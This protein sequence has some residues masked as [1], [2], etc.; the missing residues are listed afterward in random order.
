MKKNTS[1]TVKDVWEM[2]PGSTEYPSL[3]LSPLEP[4]YTVNTGGIPEVLKS[5][6]RWVNWEYGKERENDKREKIPINPRT[7]KRAE[8]NNP[9]TWGTF[10]EA[11]KRYDPCYCGLGFMLGDGWVGVDLDH[12]VNQAKE[13]EPWADEI[14][15]KIDSYSELSPSE[16]GVHII[17]RGELPHGG[18]RK[19]NIEMYDSVRFFTVTGQHLPKSPKTVEQRTETLQ[20]IHAQYI[21]NGKSDKNHHDESGSSPPP[22]TDDEIIEKARGAE[23]A[24]KFN[25]LWA[26]DKSEYD[27]DDSRADLAL[28]A[29]LAFWTKDADT[30]DRLFR[31]SGLLRPKWDERRGS[32]TYGKD[33]IQYALKTSNGSYSGSNG[34][35]PNSTC[36]QPPPADEPEET[37]GINI[38]D[39][40][41]SDAGN[42]EL[43]THLH[44]DRFKYILE[45]GI[46]VAYNGIRW[47]EAKS[48]LKDAWVDAMNRRATEAIAGM[49]P[50]DHR[51]DKIIR[52]CLSSEFNQRMCSGLQMAGPMGKL[53][54]SILEFDRK[55][56]L[57]C[58][59]NLVI[60]LG[61]GKPIGGKP[62]LMLLK[63]SDVVYDP[64]ATCPR[65]I[66]FIDEIT[67]GNKEIAE[68]LQKAVGYSLTAFN[69][70]QLFFI[71]HGG[72]NNGKTQFLAV[73]TAL[74][75][76][77]GQNAP[78]STFEEF[79]FDGARSSNDMARLQGMRLV[80]SEED[81]EGSKLN[82]GRVKLLTGGGGKITARFLYKEHFDYNPIMKLWL[83]LNHLPR[84]KGTE[85][86]IWRRVKKVPF[87]VTIP[88]EKRV[89][90]LGKWMIEHELSGILN[91][92]LEGCIKYLEGGLAEPKVVTEATDEYKE[93]SNT[94]RL[95]LK[96]E[97]V[98]DTTSSVRVGELYTAYKTW[99]E[100]TSEYAMTQKQFVRK[101]E[102]LGYAKDKSGTRSSF[103]GLRLK[104]P[105]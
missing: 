4:E 63:G 51:R 95:F 79:R 62:E 74:M 60:D 33:T 99:C 96:D 6:P 16:T 19:G 93:A 31:Q 37:Q 8:S 80:V 54:V 24:E 40:H 73:L 39:F 15:T 48:E 61:T 53:G 91:W 10:Q 103:H 12:A 64:N 85:I 27:N 88:P 45:R 82:E 70:E 43:F 92:A 25:R 21:Q 2:F 57:F 41:N 49:P 72:G 104:A 66:Q 46:W 105:E 17:A 30:I 77:Y 3:M 102:E 50:E 67:G 68:Y 42:A 58:A 71:C 1:T 5:A 90:G 56:L 81:N 47:A 36:T 100:K 13:F 84:I 35:S 18:C 76:E 97:T 59:K 14:V 9:D 26:G 52:W 34:N 86:A 11:V 32:S 87:N 44:G 28:C 69:E 22:L 75:G 29:M 55:P 83:G 94:V 38:L 78:F 89:K 98:E 101:V 20:A 65:W 7:G 23:N